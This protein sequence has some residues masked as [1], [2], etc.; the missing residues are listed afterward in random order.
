MLITS[1]THPFQGAPIDP[2]PPIDANIA[3]NRF[4]VFRDNVVKSNGGMVV[5]GT[6]ANVLVE[7]SMIQQSDVGIHV[8]M[9]TTKGGI[10]LVNNTEPKNV[11]PNYNPYYVP[12]NASD[13]HK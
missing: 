3:M 5:R 11:P 1:V 8:N 9:T 13:S 6:S 7:G 10:V 2:G 12:P 4:I